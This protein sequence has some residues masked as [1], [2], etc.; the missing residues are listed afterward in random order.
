MLDLIIL[1]NNSR[2]V[3]TRICGYF[4]KQICFPDLIFIGQGER[5]S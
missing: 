3:F 4:I 1:D 2:T 5:G